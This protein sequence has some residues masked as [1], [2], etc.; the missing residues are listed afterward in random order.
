MGDAGYEEVWAGVVLEPTLDLGTFRHHIE[1]S[2]RFGGNIDKL[3]VVENIPRNELG[4]AQP[5]LLKEMLQSI[6]EETDA[7]GA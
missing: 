6:M 1:S 2:S 7:S 3:F 5:A 4:K